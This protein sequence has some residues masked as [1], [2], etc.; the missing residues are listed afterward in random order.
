MV[1]CPFLIRAIRSS[2]MR[3]R[4]PVFAHRSDF[5]GRWCCKNIQERS[6]YFGATPSRV[7]RPSSVPLMSSCLDAI[8]V[9]AKMRDLI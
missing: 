9:S 7:S 6:G 3:I 1:L 5:K 2:I 4:C 8:T